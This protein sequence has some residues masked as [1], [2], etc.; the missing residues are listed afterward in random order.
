MTNRL[1]RGLLLMMPIL[2]VAGRQGEGQE[3]PAFDHQL[4]L[5]TR[6]AI[7]GKVAEAEAFLRQ[8]AFLSAA[9]REGHT[10]LFA[11]AVAGNLHVLD[12]VLA[13]SP[14]LDLCDVRGATALFYSAAGRTEVVRRLIQRGANINLQDQTGKS[15]LMVAVL[16]NHPGTVGLLLASGADVNH[17]DH[18]GATALFYAAEAGLFVIAEQLVKGGADSQLGDNSGLTPRQVAEAKPFPKIVDLFLRY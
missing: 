12:L 14:Q 8:P 7:E 2:C 11:A 16:M 4:E 17:R 1:L 3:L 6:L 18:V 9:D 15:P 10:A 5:F 13:L